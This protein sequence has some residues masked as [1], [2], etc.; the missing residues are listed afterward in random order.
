MFYIL[1]YLYLMLGLYFLDIDELQYNQMK[2][3]FIY[4]NIYVSRIQ[5]CLNVEEIGG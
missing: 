3:R 5:K 2:K 1:L 4:F